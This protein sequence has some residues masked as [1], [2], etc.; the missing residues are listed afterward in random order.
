MNWR[1]KITGVLLAAFTAVV[2]LPG[3]AQSANPQAVAMY[4]LALKAYKEGSVDSAV[5]FFKR[6]TEI[7][8]N[9]ADAQYNLGMI[10]QT[11]KRYRE[12]IPRFQEVL[13]I[14]PTDP[15][16]HY[17]LGLILQETGRPA[18]AKQ[19]FSNIAPSNPHF[20]DAQQ[21]IANINAQL[22]SGQAPP[23]PVSGSDMGAVPA[24]QAPAAAGPPLQQ[25]GTYGYVQQPYSAPT[26]PALV[27]PAQPGYSAAAQAG[28]GAPAQAAAQP[29]TGYYGQQPAA[30]YGASGGQPSSPP[31]QGVQQ[32]YGQT[33]QPSQVQEPAQAGLTYGQAAHAGATPAEQHA[34][35]PS[36]V[37][38]LANTTL[39]VIGTGFSAPT[40]LAFDR[41]G[42]LYVANYTANTIDRISVDGTRAQF[43]SGTN[44]KGPVGL[45]VDDSGNVYVANYLGGNVARINPAGVSTIIATGFKKPYYLTLDR[46]GNLY[47][48]QQ[49]DNSVVRI[50]LPRPI[51]SKPL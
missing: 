28:Y 4:N 45:V 6:A 36:P 39:R 9:L 44:L 27:T 37:P 33:L 46:E 23:Q 29:S 12:A 8:P 48:S 14:K 18:E 32:Q 25:P 19:H 42:N 47:V 22:A 2:P 7:D 41:L 11:Q 15:D 50:S 40:G 38:V 20:P 35:A 1:I 31:A 17:Q 21:R 3:K 5:I 30:V 26:S 51:G 10:F 43:S 16:A 13:R 24:T 49:E 34:Q